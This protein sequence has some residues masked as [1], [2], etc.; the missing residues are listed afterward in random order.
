MNVRNSFFVAAALVLAAPAVSNA[1]VDVF[2]KIDG[3]KGESRDDRHKDEIVIES[4]SFGA[5]AET[6]TGAG[7]GQRAGKTCLSEIVIVKPVDKASPQLLQA[8][9]TGQRINEATLAV[10]KAGE[11][12]LDYL[13][14]KLKEVLVTS[15]SQSGSGDGVVE[16]VSL[17][18]GTVEMSY[19][20]EDPK[21]GAGP[22]VKTTVNDCG[23]G[24]S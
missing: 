13:V 6:A 23:M 24:K 9:M 17:D 2:L 22:A 19:M 11:K 8:T 4:W 15:V 21:G 12:P 7:A 1:A 14:I 16:A 18:F 20:P 10:R 3:I 5:K